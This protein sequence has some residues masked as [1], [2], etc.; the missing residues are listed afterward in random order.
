[1]FV[2]INNIKKAVTQLL[3][4]KGRSLGQNF[5]SGSASIPIDKDLWLY[6]A[7]YSRLK[8]VAVHG[9]FKSKRKHLQILFG[10]ELN[11]VQKEGCQYMLQFATRTQLKAFDS[12]FRR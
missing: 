12:L 10:L 9:P 2:A 6:I 5:I 7:E 3:N 8:R 11:V 4:W 1:M